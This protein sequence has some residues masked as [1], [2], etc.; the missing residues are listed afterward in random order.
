MLFLIIKYTQSKVLATPQQ[1]GAMQG[2]GA[3]QGPDTV[4][5]SKDRKIAA[6]CKTWC[7]QTIR[8]R[9]QGEGTRAKVGGRILLL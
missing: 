6:G 4:I 1:L 3:K 7:R 2:T 5:R 8:D 9:T